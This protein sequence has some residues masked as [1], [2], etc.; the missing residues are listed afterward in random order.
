MTAC[1]GIGLFA[2]AAWLEPDV[3]GVGTH[4]Q[5]GL[6]PCG[7]ITSAGVPCPTCGM[8]T[9][10]ALASDGRLVEAF[11]VQPAGCALALAA[12]A[13]TLVAVWVAAT[14]SAIGGFLLDRIGART[15]WIVGGLILFAWLYKIAV[16]RLWS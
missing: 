13:A 14:G 8:T 6:P 2:V 7:W 12:A 1:A 9:A 15:G 4:H 16:F 3:S 10:F 5:L 11:I